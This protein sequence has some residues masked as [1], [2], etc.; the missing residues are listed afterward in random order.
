MSSY[1]KYDLY[2]SPPQSNSLDYCIVTQSV[3]IV[4]LGETDFM[5]VRKEI[6][7]IRSMHYQLGIELGLSSSKL[8]SIQ[9]QQITDQAFNEVL[10]AWLKQ[11]YD[12]E[13]HGSPTWRRLVE[14]VDS[15]KGGNNPELAMAIANKHLST[16]M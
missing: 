9:N 15:P 3:Y 7:D 14:A 4:F 12:V 6:E 11:D 8:N 5:D 16:G 1:N 13:R 10:L 2:P